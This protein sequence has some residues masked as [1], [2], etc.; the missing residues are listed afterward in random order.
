MSAAGAAL[1]RAGTPLATSIIR[2]LVIAVVFA[3]SLSDQPFIENHWSFPLILGAAAI[4]AVATLGLARAGRPIALAWTSM[5]DLAFVAA[6]MLASGGAFADVRLAFFL[7]PVVAAVTAGPSST[8]RWAA[9]APVIYVIVSAL[10]DPGDVPGRDATAATFSIYLVGVGLISVGI[11]EILRKREQ[12][13]EAL[14]EA[15]RTLA[16]RALEAEERERREL[17]YAL[18]DEPI[19]QLL[20]AQLDLDRATRGDTEAALSA[21]AAVKETVGQLRETVFGLYPSSLEQLGLAAALEQLAARAADRCGAEISIDVAPEATGRLDALLFTLARELLG[22]AAEHSGASRIEIELIQAD[23]DRLR[24]R[25]SDD[26]RG[27]DAARPAAALSEGHIGVASVRERAEALGGD[28]ELESEPGAGTVAT[29]TV[30]AG[31]EA[32]PA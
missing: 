29:V 2:V 14:A 10:H 12:R 5:A 7:F 25:V 21:R 31:A 3:G 11:S 13:I 6:L 20:S 32:G 1:E 28:L 16:V 24:L 23:G 27:F 18:H 30:P 26:G 9:L 17:A 4:Y 22:N 15:S 19:Q 8:A